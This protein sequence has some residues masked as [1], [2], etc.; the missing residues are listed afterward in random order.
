MTQ[1]ERLA[2][3]GAIHVAKEPTVPGP[4]YEMVDGGA[5]VTPETPLVPGTKNEDLL[6][7][8]AFRA[9]YKRAIEVVRSH[10][11]MVVAGTEQIHQTYSRHGRKAQESG[12]VL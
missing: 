6:S 2:L 11:L 12:D 3:L 10:L 7:D 8:P 1:T 9:G 4:V 5:T